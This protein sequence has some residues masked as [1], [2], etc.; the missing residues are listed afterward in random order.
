[1]DDHDF[2]PFD[3]IVLIPS[4]FSNSQIGSFEM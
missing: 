1:M 4:K 3:M 2:C